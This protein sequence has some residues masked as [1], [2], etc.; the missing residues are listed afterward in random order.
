MTFDL[1]RRGFLAGGIKGAAA[2]AIIPVSSFVPLVLEKPLPI[3]VPP[4]H[5][6]V[7]IAFTLTG[8][9]ERIPMIR[10]MSSHFVNVN[11]EAH[12]DVIETTSALSN[13]K[14]F[15]AGRKHTTVEATLLQDEFCDKL[16]ETLHK[17]RE[18]RIAFP[19]GLDH[20]LC[21]NFIADS[22]SHEYG[23]LIPAGNPYHG[24]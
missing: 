18:V 3:V 12:V 17:E 23:Q 14:T 20:C 16:I 5:N 1:T 2:A 7:H 22:V 19:L 15:S 6:L 4:R 9:P 8:K 21:G 10:N 11:I 24:I 13:Y